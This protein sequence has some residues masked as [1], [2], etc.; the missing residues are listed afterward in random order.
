MSPAS[1][2]KIE[3][4]IRIVLE[5]NVA[6]NNHNV[7]KMTSFFSVDCLLESPS[8]SPEGSLYSGKNP[9]TSYFQG[10]FRDYPD[11]SRKIE[12]IF[13]QGFQCVMRWRQTWVNDAGENKSVR[14]VDIFKVKEN[15]ICELYS[16]TKG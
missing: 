8:P 1:M 16:Y 10:F 15:R 6:F 3:N 9:V 2:S 7:E 12:D 4:A 14:G 13:S 11:V 5:F